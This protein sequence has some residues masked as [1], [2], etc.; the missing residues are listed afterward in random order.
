MKTISPV[1]TKCL[2]TGFSFVFALCA[3]LANAA[4]FNPQPDPPGKVLNTDKGQHNPPDDKVLHIPPDDKTTAPNA[5]KTLSTTLKKA[6]KTKKLDAPA[7]G[8]IDG[9]K[10]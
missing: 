1:P 8:A 5:A 9:E 3:G 4:D 2:A 6:D 7:A 10:K